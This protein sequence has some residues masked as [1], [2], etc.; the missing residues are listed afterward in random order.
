MISEEK[1]TLYL[2]DFPLFI[3]IS[4]QDILQ[5]LSSFSESIL[6]IKE[7]KKNSDKKPLSFKVIFKNF[8]I[9]FFSII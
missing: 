2:T 4:E 1:K 3:K 5:F 7:D 9:F 6:Q 8:N